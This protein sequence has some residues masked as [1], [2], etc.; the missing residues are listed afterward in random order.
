M[1]LGL[2]RLPEPVS[3]AS[4]SEEGGEGRVGSLK[5]GEHRLEEIYSL[6]S[7]GLR[8]GKEQRCYVGEEGASTANTMDSQETHDWGR[9]YL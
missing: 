1:A 8:R 2:C 4:V 3:G 5:H 6:T 7:M 9:G